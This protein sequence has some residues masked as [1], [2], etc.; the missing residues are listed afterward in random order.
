VFLGELGARLERG[1]Q[2]EIQVGRIAG[3][4]G[5]KEDEDD[6]AQSET[7]LWRLRLPK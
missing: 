1:V 2:G 3:Q 7:K 6:Q 5:E 4:P